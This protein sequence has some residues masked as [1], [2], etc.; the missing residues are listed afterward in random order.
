MKFDIPPMPVI[1]P[2]PL[3][4]HK[5][6]ADRDLRRLAISGPAACLLPVGAVQVHAGQARRGSPE[7]E[8][9]RAPSAAFGGS[10]KVRGPGAEG[11][12]SPVIL[13]SS[14]WRAQSDY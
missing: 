6:L 2:R 4:L 8:G 3:P 11:V 12:S 1:T 14:N 9:S 5:V 13:A 7:M 10:S